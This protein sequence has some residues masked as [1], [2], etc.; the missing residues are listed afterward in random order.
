MCFT[1]LASQGVSVGTSLLEEGMIDTCRKLLEN[2]GD[3]IHLP[4]D[5]VVADEVRGGLAAG[6]ASPADQIPD[7]KM[8]LDIGPAR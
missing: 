8:G 5:I 7:G 4:V 2:Y 6:D 3:V 1:F